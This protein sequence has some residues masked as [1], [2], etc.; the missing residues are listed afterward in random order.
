M[1]TVRRVPDYYTTI[2]AAIDSADEGDTI[3]VAPGSYNTSYLSI[4]KAVHL[5]SEVVGGATL[6]CDV[7]RYCTLS[8]Y[9]SSATIPVMLIEGFNIT[10][11]AQLSGTLAIGRPGNSSAGSFPP[12]L[13]VLSSRNNFNTPKLVYLGNDQSNKTFNVDFYNCSS[14]TNSSSAS[15]PANTYLNFYSCYSPN[16]TITDADIIVGS[17]DVVDTPT[18]GYGVDYGVLMADQFAT[19]PYKIA[20]VVTINGVSPDAIQIKLYRANEEGM[21]NA[22]WANETPDPTTGAWSFDYLPT[23]HQYYVAVV[24][25]A[26]NEPKLIGPYTPAQV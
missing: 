26:G 14:N 15:S 6:F 16:P 11:T 2:Q 25:P 21:E 12:A 23:D 3:L 5:V 1:A 9:M 7:Y 22:A 17:A 18:V 10:S 20:G 13:K 8:F 4:T 24:P 19:T